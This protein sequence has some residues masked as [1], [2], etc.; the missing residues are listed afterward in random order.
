MYLKLG[1]NKGTKEIR[2]QI[3][4]NNICDIRYQHSE[5]HPEIK[6][7]IKMKICLFICTFR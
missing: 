7:L 5:L 3:H 6:V 1:L 4:Q 2:S